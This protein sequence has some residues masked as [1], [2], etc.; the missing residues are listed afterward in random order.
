MLR[1]I[2]Q[3][4]NLQ[5]KIETDTL[6][7]PIE[8]VNVLAETPTGDPNN[9][10]MVGGHFDSV[11]H[12][13]GI[14]DN[15]S[16]TATLLEIAIQMARLEIQP[17]NKVRFAFWS[18]EELGLLGSTH[19]VDALEKNYPER[20]DDIALYLNFDMI[21]SPNYIRGIYQLDRNAPVGTAQVTQLL[22]DYFDS[23]ELYWEPIPIG[24]RSD[25]APFMKADI[26][27]G[28]LFSGAENTLSRLQARQYGHEQS[29]IATDP[30]YH[31]ACDTIENISQEALDE[32]GDA[33]AHALLAL[34]METRLAER[35]GERP[36]V[37][38][39]SPPAM[40]RY[41]LDKP[42]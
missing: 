6:A 21:G 25:H 22:T 39:T 30:C 17:V 38:P 18:A 4:P 5:I 7:G 15:G 16:G 41:N 10:V 42:F 1:Q 36:L 37:N 14:N 34:A 20:V 33:A 27:V 3:D 26:A 29:G 19:Y 28:G 13:P 9:V 12:G 40:P 2:E 11:Q 23:R 32:L 8:T 31:Q 35:W 24:G